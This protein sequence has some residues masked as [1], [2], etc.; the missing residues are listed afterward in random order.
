MTKNKQLI[1]IERIPQDSE[2]PILNTFRGT[3]AEIDTY[4]RNQMH[5]DEYCDA[6]MSQI[7]DAGFGEIGNGRGVQWIVIPE[8][9]HI[10]L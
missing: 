5:E 3:F 2:Q 4:V 7:L 8:E 10:P 9:G 6:T 1:L